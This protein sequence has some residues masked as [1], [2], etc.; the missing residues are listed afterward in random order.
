LE[1]AKNTYENLIKRLKELSSKNQEL[2][3]NEDNTRKYED[4]FKE[5]LGDD[6]QTPQVLALIWE[7]L[8]SDL[9]SEEKYNLIINWDEVLGLNLKEKTEEVEKTWTYQGRESGIRIEA[10][11]ELSEEILDLV[12]QREM[13]RKVKI[14]KRQMR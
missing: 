6:L 1:K 10:N 14:G 2:R 8:K 13:A 11:F 3:I 7:L 9:T 12:D 4:K 5:I